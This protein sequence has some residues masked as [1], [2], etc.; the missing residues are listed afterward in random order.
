MIKYRITFSLI[1]VFF[2]GMIISV[3]GYM[4]LP[5]TPAELIG[6]FIGV[7]CVF[8]CCP[9]CFL[10]SMI[11]TR[12]AD[13]RQK[14]S[15]RDKDIYLQKQAEMNLE[16]KKLEIEKEKVKLETMKSKT[17]TQVSNAK[18][19][20]FCK[21]CGKQIDKESQICPFCGSEL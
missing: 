2:I 12:R 8:L 3:A 11:D 14:R 17:L 4:A 7:V 13:S 20:K 1:V 15:D 10:D 18:L 9:G 5:G 21:K 6:V 19:K 16:M